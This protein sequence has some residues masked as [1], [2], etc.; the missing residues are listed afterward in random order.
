[1]TVTA[2]DLSQYDL[3]LV[4]DKSGSMQTND[5]PPA[6]L[7]RWEAA[8]EAALALAHAAAKYDQDGITVVTFNNS[9]KLYDGVT[10][11][12][13]T[14]VFAENEPQGGTDTAGVL[15][16]LFNRYFTSK[17]GGEAK[18]QIIQ[19]ITDGAPNDQNA[20][21]RVI[22]DAT[23]K[24]DRDEE[25]AVQFIQYGNDQGARAFLQFLDDELEGKGAKF[26]IVDAKTAEEAENVPLVEL[27]LAA[28]N[29]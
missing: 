15:K 3:I 18:P 13:V 26:D 16:M 27:L 11:D 25:L 2:T 17:A 1:M 22:I 9:H 6:G 21:A 23:Q 4:I 29:D 12:K 28:V 7:T 10:P 14:Q 19:V 5:G 8:E 24:M 20:V